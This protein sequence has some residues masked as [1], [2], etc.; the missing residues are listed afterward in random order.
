MNRSGCLVSCPTIKNKYARG[1]GCLRYEHTPNRRLKGP[2]QTSTQIGRAPQGPTRLGKDYDIKEGTH[3][4]TLLTIIPTPPCTNQGHKNISYRNP[5]NA[6][7]PEYSSDCDVRGEVVVKLGARDPTSL[8][9]SCVWGVGLQS[10]PAE[11]RYWP[12]KPR[13]TQTTQASGKGK[14]RPVS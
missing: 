7:K 4:V 9:H 8:I 12:A 14:K 5:P 1:G 2:L 13:S 10:P 11:L 6:L 3:H